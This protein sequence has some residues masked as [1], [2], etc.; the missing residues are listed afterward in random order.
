MEPIRAR[1]AAQLV[2]EARPIQVLDARVAVPGRFAGVRRCV[3][4]A[5]LHPRRC[6]PIRCGVRAR[7]P[8]ER[9][10]ALAAREDV[11]P[12]ASFERVR[13]GLAKEHVVLAVTP[14]HVAARTAHQ[15]VP[16]R[17]AEVRVAARR[18][19]PPVRRVH[20]RDEIDRRTSLGHPVARHQL[21][22]VQPRTIPERQRLDLRLVLR[23]AP[24]RHPIGQ[25]VERCIRVVRILERDLERTA[26]EPQHDV[27]DAE[28]PGEE[29]DVAGAA[30]ALHPVDHHP[31]PD[32]V[33]TVAPAEDVQIVVRAAPEGVRSRSAP[34]NV[35]ARTAV[36][37]IVTL[38]AEEHIVAAVSAQRVRPGV[39]GE[40]VPRRPAGEGV[41]APAAAHHHPR[42]TGVAE[43]VVAAPAEH[44][45]ETMPGQ[46][47]RHPR[48]AFHEGDIDARASV[49]RPGRKV[50]RIDHQH[51]VAGTAA[52]PIRSF[53]SDQHV[54]AA[55]PFER[56]V[57]PAPD[58]HL[59]VIPASHEPVG[60][61]M[62]HHPVDPERSR[63]E[64]HPGLR[65]R[66]INTPG[67]AQRDR[68]TP[69]RLLADAVLRVAKCR[70]VERT[71]AVRIPVAPLA[72]DPVTGDRALH[73]VARKID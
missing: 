26:L 29:Q 70:V 23:P 36:Q 10:A 15:H 4:E 43:A 39:S 73:T 47:D 16:P 59:P 65:P 21:P 50:I 52:Q 6:T 53:T 61:V 58:E 66:Q 18:Q 24:D 40:D 60:S 7:A 44:R 17:A 55:A 14:K 13:P 34:Q 19:R 5:R 22:E 48:L 35:A 1:V 64:P 25:R 2:V 62:T 69:V 28:R 67:L 63:V 37:R 27:A 12:G 45:F 51:V 38:A 42:F 20:R 46:I 31:V 9:I 11:V 56:V 54:E 32:L 3:R 57:T 71:R 49:H 41:V 30:L 72:E 8:V 68:Q 33:A